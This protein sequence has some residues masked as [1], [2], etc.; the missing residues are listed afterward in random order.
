MKHYTRPVLSLCPS[1]PKTRDTM[2]RKLH[3]PLLFFLSLDTMILHPNPTSLRKGYLTIALEI[4]PYL[5][6]LVYL[7]LNFYQPCR[8]INTNFVCFLT[9][10]FVVQKTFVRARNVSGLIF[11][12]M[13]LSLC[14]TVRV[15]LASFK[16]TISTEWCLGIFQTGFIPTY[17]P[18]FL[19]QN[20]YQTFSSHHYY[21]NLPETCISSENMLSAFII[22]NNQPRKIAPNSI[23]VLAPGVF[24][25][26]LLTRI[27]T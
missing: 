23:L 1:R 8:K 26:S 11:K 3:M 27:S 18:Q 24:P 16:T 17:I 12:T 13:I 2:K 21:R 20:H 7:L 10:I 9:T 6:S 19:L 5:Q 4:S 14:M 25:L 22:P 15:R